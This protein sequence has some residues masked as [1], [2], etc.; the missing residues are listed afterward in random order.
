MNRQCQD[1]MFL[2]TWKRRTHANDESSSANR[3]GFN[4]D[5]WQRGND[6]QR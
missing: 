5:R 2:S 1:E 6:E 3:T 4:S